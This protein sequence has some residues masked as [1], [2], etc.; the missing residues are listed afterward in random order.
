MYQSFTAHSA[1]IATIKKTKKQQL[2]NG[3]KTDIFQRQLKIAVWW[4]NLHWN[5]SSV[6]LLSN[7]PGIE[8]NARYTQ[9]NVQT[10]ASCKY[11]RYW[12]KKNKLVYLIG[13]RQRPRVEIPARPGVN[14]VC[15]AFRPSFIESIS[16]LCCSQTLT[17]DQRI[18]TLMETLT[19][20]GKSADMW[21]AHAEWFDHRGQQT[22]REL[23][24]VVPYRV[25]W[26]GEPL[27]TISNNELCVC[28][29]VCV[30]FQPRKGFS[31]LWAWSPTIPPITLIS[32]VGTVSEQMQNSHNPTLKRQCSEC[33]AGTAEDIGSVL[34]RL[35]TT[36]M[37]SGS[38]FCFGV[39]HTQNTPFLPL[40]S[41][42]VYMLF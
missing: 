8:V 16:C 4:G 35:M 39:R 11:F 7:L 29:C 10:V 15:V 19:V 38:L 31:V 30:R 33:E 13:W 24:L 20:A 23:A 27:L 9:S 42:K 26:N 17:W 40:S 12:S 36:S 21:C 32:I 1:L 41:P 6:L 22:S 37:T 18:T 3:L 25:S 14:Q 5:T 34:R 28:V 2:E